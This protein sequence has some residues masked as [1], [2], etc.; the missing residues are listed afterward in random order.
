[1][2]NNIRKNKGFTLMEL[3]VVIIIMGILS[4]AGIKA[5]SKSNEN[6]KYQTTLR[7]MEALKIAVVG[8]ERLIQNGKRIA[9][10]YIGDVGVMPPTLEDLVTN[11]AGEDNW[12]GPYMKQNFADN[13]SDYL[14]D[15]WNDPY[16]YDGVTP[17]ITT[18]GG[19]TAFAIYL[20]KTQAASDLLANE[21]TG[22]V[23]DREGNLPVSTDVVNIHIVVTLGNGTILPA[24]NPGTD[25]MYTVPNV[26]IGLQTVTATHDSVDSTFGMEVWTYNDIRVYPVNGGQ[27]DVKFNQ[28][29]PGW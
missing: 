23:Y 10:G 9:F 7:E 26:P 14:F 24:V 20:V 16:T 22:L 17:A 13:P 29:L 3:V 12:L 15:G 19:G 1:M 27:R 5:I 6:A 2:N 21:I 8:D 11:V 28:I 4:L 18:D 25:G